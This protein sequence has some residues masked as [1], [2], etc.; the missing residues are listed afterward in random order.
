MNISHENRLFLQCLQA[1][2]SGNT[3]DKIKGVISLS[4]NWEEVL[5]SAFWHGI[6]PLLYNNLKDIQESHLIP[7]E[8]MAQL[9]TAYHGNLAR[10]MYLYAELKR[11]LETFSNKGVKVIVLKGA[12]LAKTVY[13][14]IGLRP[15]SD[16]DLLVKRED[17]P[18][19][20]N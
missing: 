8:V 6:A 10:N 9:R 5:E 15:M 13:G 11:I 7:R 14:D 4:L 18:H 17:L 2:I 3:G 16:I 19:A 12:A 20:E 1:S